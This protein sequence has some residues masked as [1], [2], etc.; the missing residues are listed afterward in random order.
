MLSAAAAADGTEFGVK[1]GSKFARREKVNTQEVQ[2][3]RQA[4]A[5]EIFNR[6]VGV[7]CE[8]AFTVL[9]FPVP[10]C[11]WSCVFCCQSQCTGVGGDGGAFRVI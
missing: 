7:G 6:Q 4:I 11:C 8:G 10:G 2:R 5:H 3:Q 9:G 1:L